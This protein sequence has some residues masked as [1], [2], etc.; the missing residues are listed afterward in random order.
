M[1]T[2]MNVEFVSFTKDTARWSEN[3]VCFNKRPYAEHHCMGQI[4]DLRNF[5]RLNS[6]GP[7]S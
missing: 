7:N 2:S 4:M 3:D 5:K 6:N 1:S